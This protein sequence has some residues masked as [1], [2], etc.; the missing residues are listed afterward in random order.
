MARR[1]ATP[2]CRPPTWTAPWNWSRGTRSSAAADHCK[3]ARRPCQ[4]DRTVQE[5][6]Q[7]DPPARGLLLTAA[8]RHPNRTDLRELRA[9]FQP[10]DTRGAIVCVPP[11]QRDNGERLPGLVV[12]GGR[13]HGGTVPAG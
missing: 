12:M 7:P 9:V 2:S 13:G 11:C 4:A 5:E 8:I 3:S 1:T 6:R 10:S